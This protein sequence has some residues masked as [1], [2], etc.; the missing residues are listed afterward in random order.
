[1][2][3]RRSEATSRHCKW[4]QPRPD[5]ATPT[6]LR[7]PDGLWSITDYTVRCLGHGLLGASDDVWNSAWLTWMTCPKPRPA[8]RCRRSPLPSARQ[9]QNRDTSFTAGERNAGN[10]DRGSQSR[11]SATLDCTTVT[12]AVCNRHPPAAAT[13]GSSCGSTT[14]CSVGSKFPVLAS[15]SN[16]PLLVAYAKL[17]II[18][19]HRL[20]TTHQHPNIP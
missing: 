19:L 6:Q 2:V 17:E 8:C 11:S 5:R 1:V 4:Y 13:S 9:H 20:S 12:T 14:G 7:Y 18:G 10:G 16:R 3:W 15:P